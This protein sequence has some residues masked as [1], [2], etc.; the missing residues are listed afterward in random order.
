MERAEEMRDA[1]GWTDPVVEAFK[2]GVDV[3]LLD[4]Q[5]RRTPEERM[6]RVEDMQHA[7]LEL[8]RAAR[9]PAR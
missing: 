9:G 1:P 6:R 7:V 8:R 3:T 5:L 2:P 4:E